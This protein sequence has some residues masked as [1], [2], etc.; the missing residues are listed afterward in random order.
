MSAGQTAY[1]SRAGLVM[2][3][4]LVLWDCWWWR[5]LFV[6]GHGQLVGMMQAGGYDLFYD[7]R[8]NLM[9]LT[10]TPAALAILAGVTDSQTLARLLSLGLFGVPACF[11]S[12]ALIRARHDPALLAAV[13]VT[14]GLVFV[15]TS[16]FIMG[17]HNSIC[18][19][20]IFCAVVMST[21]RQTTSGDGLMLVLSALVLLR[22]HEATTAMGPLLALLTGW[23]LQGLGWR[24]PGA[25]TWWLALL[26]FAG[27]GLIGLQSMAT[28]HNKEQM[29]A[30]LGSVFEFANNIQFTLPL[31]ATAV[32]VLGAVC[33]PQL[34][35]SRKV[36]VLAGALLLL[37]ALSPLLWLGEGITRPFPKAP[38]G[39]RL[40]ALGVTSL[41]AV[42]VVAFASPAWQRLP[43]FSLLRIPEH[44]GR[45]LRFAAMVFIAALPADLL[46]TELWR[47]SE[48]A[49]QHVIATRPGFVP[50]DETALAGEPYRHFIEVWL[51][52]QQ[53][54]VLRR[55]LSDGTVI[56]PGDFKGWQNR[57]PTA[58]MPGVFE[59]Y[60]G[61]GSGE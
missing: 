38:Y 31:A 43:A 19:I 47:R 41:I 5:G 17:E 26:L 32:V 55:K 29:Q 34:L 42:A 30:A 53:S 14:L 36:F 60:W 49:F 9:A 8:A 56:P 6:D 27:S 58:E 51:L 54:L 46:L 44:A 28:F 21:A 3:L 20:V 11:Y 57:E 13:F 2:L 24:G 25:A 18:A 33:R 7:S 40:A 45:L 61:G 15:P 1:L 52:P 22:S 12:A 35:R 39:S 50:F 59:F 10:Q 16:F 48:V 23:R 37:L 4:L